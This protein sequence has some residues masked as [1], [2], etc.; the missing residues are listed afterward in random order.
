[1]AERR[2]GSRTW[3]RSARCRVNA[4]ERYRGLDR[5][6]RICYIIYTIHL[7]AF[8]ALAASRRGVAKVVGRCLGMMGCRTTL[9]PAVVR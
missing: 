8:C 5:L 9:F 4:A 6:W 2:L 7:A 1:M 3:G